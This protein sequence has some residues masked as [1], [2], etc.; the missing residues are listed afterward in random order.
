M[1]KQ[2][3]CI[4]IVESTFVYFSP[5]DDYWASLADYE[6]LEMEE[7]TNGCIY[8]EDIMGYELANSPIDAL[9][10]YAKRHGYPNARDC[11]YLYENSD[12]RISVVAYECPPPEIEPD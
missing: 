8:D 4:A 1:E 10:Q 9:E 3:Y 12:E 6:S 5:E 11:F 2:W 7:Y